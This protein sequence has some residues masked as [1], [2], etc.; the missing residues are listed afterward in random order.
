MPTMKRGNSSMSLCRLVSQS[1]S[2]HISFRQDERQQRSH[3]VSTIATKKSKYIILAKLQAQG[4]VK[5]RNRLR[6]RCSQ[7]GAGHVVTRGKKGSSLP[8]QQHR[9]KPCSLL[10]RILSSYGNILMGTVNISHLDFLEFIYIC[11]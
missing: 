5:K 10:H 6:F 9:Y 4:N 1:V 7:P 3:H 8:Y 11:H 2:T